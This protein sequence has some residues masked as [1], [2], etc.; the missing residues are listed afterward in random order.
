M[1]AVVHLVRRVAARPPGAW[2]TG[3]S[4][5]VLHGF[6]LLLAGAVMAPDSHTYAHWSGRLLETGFDFP[7]VLA[8]AETT[9]PPIL[10]LAFGTLLALLRLGLG[11]GWPIA[12]VALNA[13]AHIILGLLLVRLAA[14]VAGAAAGWAALSLYLLCFGLLQWVPFVLSDATFA[15]IA[16]TIFFLAS[17]RLLA[18]VRGWLP[19]I[20]LAGLGVFY[21]PTGI[22]LVPD[23]LW[24]A[25]LAR[26]RRIPSRTLMVAAAAS[27]VAAAA[28]LFA[29]LMQDPS[30]WPFD[31][32]RP[33]FRNTAGA[34]GLG[35]V[36][37]MRRE[38]YHAP[39][40]LLIDYVAISADRFVHFF[41]I[42]AADFSLAHW[43]VE[44]AFFVP[45]YG[46]AGWAVIALWRGRTDFEPGARKVLLAAI[47]AILSYALFH[48]FVQLDFDW[49]YRAPILPHLILLASAG[50]ADL[51]RRR[52][53]R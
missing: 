50:A 32:L 47:G 15:L 13:V 20:G 30:R 26:V 22:V 29:W 45:A 48:A 16:F 11:E 7:A 2:S 38:T 46:L 17:R 44:L 18:E 8:E 31:A 9:F 40:D 12:L 49:R 35:E 52:R 25:W 14:R 28:L 53:A 41:A 10:Y 33:A 43:I 19:V 24:A 6:Y 27:A 1:K 34:Y 51:L 3:L 42:G 36:V 37:S 23:R 4:I 21:R 39:P 5:L